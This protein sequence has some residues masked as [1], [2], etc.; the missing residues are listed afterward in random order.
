MS[1]NSIYFIV[2]SVFVVVIG[3]DIY[4]WSK[5]RKIVAPE[6]RIKLLRKK[7]D[8][9][10][11]ILG[12]T[13]LGASILFQINLLQYRA[14]MEHKDFELITLKDFKGYKLPNQT[15]HGEKQFAFIV[16]SIEWT[17]GGKEVE[18]K[19]LFHPSRSY[20][21]SQNSS[22]KHLLLH[23]MYHFHITE[24]F[25]RKVREE[26]SLSEQVPASKKIKEIVAFNL[27]LER[28]M[29]ADYDY[30]TYHGYVLKKQKS[31]QTKSDSLLSLRQNYSQTKIRYR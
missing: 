17:S 3:Y 16:T 18:V 15:L 31:W 5:G 11:L 1:P 6:I 9:T 2:S 14:P 24:I 26:L 19:S 8:F 13:F 20:T 12:L 21:F 30:E 23:E 4:N 25:A 27:A 7:I 22:D 10:I 28:E 29:Q